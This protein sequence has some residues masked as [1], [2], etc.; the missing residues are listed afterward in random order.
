MK[1]IFDEARR[2][3]LLRRVDQL[4]PDRPRQWGRMTAHQAV[5]HLS[6]SLKAALGDRPLPAKPFGL[7]R[8]LTRFLAFTLPVPWPKGVPTS[9]GVDAEKEGTPP[10]DFDADVA[11]LRTLMERIA[12]TDGRGLPAHHVWGP[13]SRSMWGR[14]VY[15]HVAHH[16]RQFGA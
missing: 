3:E 14:Y 6:D 2:A 7:Q 15:R 4:R 13:M 11:E 5:C 10:G 12:E 8:R 9:P 16:L 1:T